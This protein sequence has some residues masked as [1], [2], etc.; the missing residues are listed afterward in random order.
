MT[1]DEFTAKVIQGGR[2]EETARELIQE[3][4]EVWRE[5]I[6]LEELLPPPYLD[7]YP[8]R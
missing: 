5:A 7:V 2:D 8:E 3:W 4:R 1:E 6:P